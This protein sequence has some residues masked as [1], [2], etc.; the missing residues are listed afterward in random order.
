VRVIPSSAILQTFRL[1]QEP[2]FYGRPAE[3]TIRHFRFLMGSGDETHRTSIQ[4]RVEDLYE[5]RDVWT[6]AKR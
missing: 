3:S 6:F 5:R 2:I 1:M 4:S